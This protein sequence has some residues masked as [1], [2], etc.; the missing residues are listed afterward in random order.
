M[1]WRYELWYCK[2]GFNCLFCQRIVKSDDDQV[3]TQIKIRSIYPGRRSRI[4]FEEIRYTDDGRSDHFT[5]DRDSIL[6]LC[7]EISDDHSDI[8]CDTGIW[9][10]RIDR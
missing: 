5:W 9:I 8:I 3:F 4:T 7:K 6:I 10:Y 2:A 1:R